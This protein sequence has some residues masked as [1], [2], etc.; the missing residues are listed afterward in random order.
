MMKVPERLKSVIE[1]PKQAIGIAI[2][3]LIF[4]SIALIVTAVKTHGA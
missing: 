2:L 4:A 3:A 1:V